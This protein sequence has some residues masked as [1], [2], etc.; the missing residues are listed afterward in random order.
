M[1][2][3]LQQSLFTYR[4]RRAEMIFTEDMLHSHGNILGS[5]IPIS[6]SNITVKR[7]LYLEGPALRSSEGQPS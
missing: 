4:T 1:V 7:C 6:S 2:K 3:S 5:D